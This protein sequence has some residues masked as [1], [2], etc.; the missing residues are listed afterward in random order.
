MVAPLVNKIIVLSNGNSNG[1]IA[2]IFIGGQT[3]PNSI[4]G[5]NAEC[6][7]AQNIPKKNIASLTINNMKPKF[8]PFLTAVV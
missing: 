1:P 5:A 6:I 4:V 8:I 7:Y 3:E 2:C